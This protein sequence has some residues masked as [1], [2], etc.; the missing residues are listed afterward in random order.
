MSTALQEFARETM[1]ELLQELTVEERLEFLKSLS[2][3]QRVQG[4]SAAELRELAN[5]MDNGA[6]GETVT[7]PTK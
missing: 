1:H 6:S 4:L 2:P 5:K 3:E 7:R